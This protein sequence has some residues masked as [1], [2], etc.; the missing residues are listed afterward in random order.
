LLGLD[1]EGGLYLRNEQGK[2]VA[3]RIGEV[4]LRPLA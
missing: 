3:V 4:H 1:P 2:S